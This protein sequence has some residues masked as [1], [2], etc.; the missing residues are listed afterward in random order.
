MAGVPERGFKQDSKSKRRNP[1][2][3]KAYR[4]E[5]KSF[6]LQRLCR[7]LSRPLW[8]G[9]VPLRAMPGPPRARPWL[10]TTVLVFQRPWPGS[11]GLLGC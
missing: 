7:G 9:G 10:K 6:V 1:P 3:L 11:R 8:P 2:H 5:A 4:K